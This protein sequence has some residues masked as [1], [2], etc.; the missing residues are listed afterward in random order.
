M[1]IIMILGLSA[2]V[3]TILT[4]ICAFGSFLIKKYSRFK[5]PLIILFFTTGLI[6]STFSIYVWIQPALKVKQHQDEYRQTLATTPKYSYSFVDGDQRWAE[7]RPFDKGSCLAQKQAY[8]ISMTTQGHY[9]P[10][11]NQQASFTN[12]MCEVRMRILSG[13]TGGIVFRDQATRN[14]TYYL[15]INEDGAYNLSYLP[16]SAS[17]ESNPLFSGVSDSL[18]HDQILNQASLVAIRADG[19]DLAIYIDGNYVNSIQDS[20]IASGRIGL[21][22]QKLLNNTDIVFDQ[23]KIWTLS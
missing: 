15:S 13:D 9:Y 19:S 4:G 2:N 23:V 1:D 11:Y 8:Y 5:T 3:V 14:D 20:S 12:F 7:G 6:A 10:C 22:S 21:V 18:Y 16:N 17:D